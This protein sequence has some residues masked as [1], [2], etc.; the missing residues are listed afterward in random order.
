[1]DVNID[2]S[3]AGVVTAV[4]S[5]TVNGTDSRDRGTEDEHGRVDVEVC[6]RRHGSPAASRRWTSRSTPWVGTTGSVTTACRRIGF[7]ADLG[8]D[9]TEA[10]PQR[11]P[12]SPTRE[13]P[14][15]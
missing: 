7:D 14:A 8:P 13:T 11:R 5:L 2:L 15:A 3:V 9:R 1:V 6:K 12:G 10:P 4:D